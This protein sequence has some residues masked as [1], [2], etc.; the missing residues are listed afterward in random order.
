M[1]KFTSSVNEITQKLHKLHTKY[2][3]L[4]LFSKNITPL[5][6]KFH[7]CRD[8]DQLCVNQHIKLITIFFLPPVPRRVLTLVL[9]NWRQIVLVGKSL[10]SS[11]LLH[12]IVRAPKMFGKW[13]ENHHHLHHYFTIRLVKA[14][15]MN[16]HKFGKHCFLI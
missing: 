4:L 13:L 5:G 11:L 8:I 16:N 15:K 3:E 1:P 10:S 7:A 9:H 14:P 6:K 12:N 2:I